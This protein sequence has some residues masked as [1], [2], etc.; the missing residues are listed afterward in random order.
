MVERLGT[1]QESRRAGIGRRYGPPRSARAHKA[2]PLAPA[3]LAL[4]AVVVD[5][6]TIDDAMGQATQSVPFHYTASST[7]GLVEGDSTIWFPPGNYLPAK[8][9]AQTRWYWKS[10]RNV[11][12]NYRGHFVQYCHWYNVLVRLHCQPDTAV[13][14]IGHYIA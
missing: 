13:G 1:H 11:T 7:R 5:G 14:S 10:S 2:R 12:Q 8:A 6:P 4:A 3:L 9:K